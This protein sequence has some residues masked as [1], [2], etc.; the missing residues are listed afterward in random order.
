MSSVGSSFL[1]IHAHSVAAVHTIIIAK[2]RSLVKNICWGINFHNS[3][4]YKEKGNPSVSLRLSAQ[5]KARPS[6]A[7]S[8]KP[9]F[10]GQYRT[11]I[12]RQM[13][14]QIFRQMKQKAE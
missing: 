7:L 9:D 13:R 2:I 1:L 6:G 4:P 10:L 12:V 5:H 14:R 3:L 11:K 8:G